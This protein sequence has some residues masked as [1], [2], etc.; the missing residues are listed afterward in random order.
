[1]NKD[2]IR[3]RIWDEMLKRGVARFPLPPHNRIPNFIGAES[4]SSL[5]TR[6]REWRNAEIVKINPDS[7]QK[8]VRLKA[9][10]SGKLLIMPT[11]RIKEGFLLLNPKKISDFSRASTIKG[12][13]ELGERLTLEEI[14]EMVIDLIVEGS[15]AV[16]SFGE[17]IG[18]GM[19]YGELEFGILLELGVIDR[20]VPIAT[21]VHEIQVLD[22]S[23]PQEPYDVPVDYIITPKRTIRASRGERPDGIYWNLLDQQ[24]LEEIPVLK[25][26]AGNLRI[27]D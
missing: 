6:L 4:A 19:G 8:P 5:L 16:N 24:K 21:T 15:V 7:P 26:L 18:K 23:L 12:A 22:E 2:E 11:P 25:E 17:R 10:K 13:F 1:M 3:K 20:D 14:K 9:L 27:R